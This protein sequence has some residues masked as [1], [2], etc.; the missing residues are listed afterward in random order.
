[1][2]ARTSS[3][4]KP[5]LRQNQ[6]GFV[7]GGPVYF[8]KFYDGRNKTFCLANYEGWRIRTGNE[9]QLRKRS[10]TRRSL[11]ATFST[12]GSS[13]LWHVR[14]A[15][16][17][18]WQQS[19]HADR[20]GYRPPFPNVT[21]R[22]SGSRVW[23]TSDV[24]AGLPSAKLFTG[25]QLHGVQLCVDSVLPDSTGPADLSAGSDLWQFRAPS[26]SATPRRTI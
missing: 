5:R 12:S 23:R 8:P 19:L 18:G 20:S 25:I 6:F 10:E 1:M 26:S 7:L 2:P 15:R 14:L 16:R 3:L 13:G 17:L 22:A 9:P 4:R 21:I 24:K 11:A